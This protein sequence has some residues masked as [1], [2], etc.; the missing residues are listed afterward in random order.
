MLK[1]VEIEILLP[2]DSSFITFDVNKQSFVIKYLVEDKK[3]NNLIR[4]NLWNQKISY[5]VKTR[6]YKSSLQT[7]KD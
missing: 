4:E 5:Y 1:K 2:P 6:D 7:E 3:D